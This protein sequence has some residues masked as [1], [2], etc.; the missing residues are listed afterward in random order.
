VTKVIIKKLRSSSSNG[1]K[2]DAPKEFVRRHDGQ[3]IHIVDSSSRT[4]DDDLVRAFS[5]NIAAERQA[6]T[7]IFGSPD[8]TR[9]SPKT[10]FAK[11]LLRGA[12]EIAEFL[13]G[14]RKGRRKLYHLVATSNL[15][16]FKIGSTICARESMLR[17]WIKEREERHGRK[18]RKSA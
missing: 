18:N 13:F 14:D 16:V 1:R 5:A 2:K 12:E 9:D 7:A 15:P 4:F 11:D 10:E 8:R 3:T 17:R 6:N